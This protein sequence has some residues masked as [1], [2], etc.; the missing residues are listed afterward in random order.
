MFQNLEF[1][2]MSQ[3][4]LIAH[5][6]RMT[7]EQDGQAIAERTGLDLLNHEVAYVALGDGIFGPTAG[8]SPV[9]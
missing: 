1:G 7:I 3:I 5:K 4:R 9:A 2:N 8:V 6:D